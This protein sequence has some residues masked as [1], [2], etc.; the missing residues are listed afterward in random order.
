MQGSGDGRMSH[1]EEVC[2]H[3]KL[4]S[5]WVFLMA[6]AYVRNVG[7]LKVQH[8]QKERARVPWL[9]I[10]GYLTESV[11]P[12]AEHAPLTICKLQCPRS[13]CDLF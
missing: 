5:L 8:L 3:A 11:I 4:G 9:R 2:Q 6:V 1:H 7:Q 10:G 12:V 13:K